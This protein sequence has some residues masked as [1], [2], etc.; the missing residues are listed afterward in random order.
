MGEREFYHAKFN[1]LFLE[2]TSYLVEHPEFAVQ[3]PDGAEVMLLDSHDPEYNRYMLAA[4]RKTPPE[5]PVVYVDVG[6]LAQ[7]R[8]RLCNPRVLPIP[9]AYALA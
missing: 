1:E 7:V 8:S 5:H 6:E 2:F 3:I 9:A 4:I